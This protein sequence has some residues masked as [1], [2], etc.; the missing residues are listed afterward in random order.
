MNEGFWKVTALYTKYSTPTCHHKKDLLIQHKPT[1]SRTT[2]SLNLHLVIEPVANPIKSH[3]N[4][5]FVFPITLSYWSQGLSHKINKQYLFERYGCA[6]LTSLFCPHKL[7]TYSSLN[8]SAVFNFWPTVKQLNR[9]I[10]DHMNAIFICHFCSLPCLRFLLCACFCPCLDT[11]AMC[12]C[13]SSP[14]QVYRQFVLHPVI[15][16][17]RYTHYVSL[18]MRHCS[19]SLWREKAD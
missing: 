11:R 10:N 2:K 12:M 9:Q 7:S 13:G 18:S 4:K 1:F 6:L 17:Q 19:N 16:A 15:M 14:F 3:I 8:K 5:I